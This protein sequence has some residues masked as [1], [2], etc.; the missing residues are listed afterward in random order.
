MR[1]PVCCGRRSHDVT[2]GF[3]D[4]LGIQ[5]WVCPRCHQR[6]E[7]ATGE[8]AMLSAEDP[9]DAAPGS[10]EKMLVFAAR[11]ACGEA[12]FHARD[13][14]APPATTRPAEASHLPKGVEWEEG[15][16][17]F[18]VRI[19]HPK[20]GRMRHVGRFRELREAIEMLEFWRA[21]MAPR[22]SGNSQAGEGDG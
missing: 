5:V 18:R 17:R 6:R 16:Q 2:D 1:A 21:E 22:A 13:V 14:R 12:L 3:D 4:D 7:V 10:A 8:D 15:R 11:F 19:A 20:T 9:T